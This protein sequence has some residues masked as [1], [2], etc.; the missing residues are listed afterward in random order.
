MYDH[1]GRAM[2]QP[3]ARRPEA[4]LPAGHPFRVRP[5]PLVMAHRGDSEHAPENTL[6]AF[7]RAL[8]E[9]A[10]VLETDLWLSADGHFVCHHDATLER[11]TGDPRAVTEVGLADLARLAVTGRFGPAFAAERVPTLEQLLDD[12][13]PAVVLVVE[14]KDP[15]FARPELA[16]RLAAQLAERAAAFTT[17]AVS[18]DL[19]YLAVPVGHITLRHLLPTQPTELLGPAWP[20]VFANPFYVRMAHRRGQLVGALDPTP[21]RRL[22]WYL[23]RGADAVLSND[24]GAT[25]QALDRL[26]AG[27]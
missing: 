11:M 8:D 7:R 15:R 19:G 14:L 18:F 20:L 23:A 25:R 1:V 9:G 13:P 2:T 4:L 24:P 26:R 6:A 27:A 21:G 17:V 5:R 16:A 10:D 12:L 22:R 3:T